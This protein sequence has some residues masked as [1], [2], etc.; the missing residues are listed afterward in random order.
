MSAL[1]SMWIWFVSVELILA[2]LPLLTLVRLFDRDPVRYRTGRWF[3]RL[4]IAMTKMNPSWRLHISG[5][6]I[7]DPR[8]PY[9][10]VSNHQSH[11]DI[12][13]I[14]HLP[15]EMKW[16]AKVE[17]FRLPVVGWMLRLA[18]DIP[19]DRQDRRQGV[20]VLARAAHYL[21]HRCSVMF[22]PEGTRSP[23]GR[24]HRFNEGAFRLAIKCG[25]PI[26]PLAV[27][28]SRD[29]LPKHSWKF[30]RPTDIFL[31]V[32]PPVETT[33][34]DVADTARLCE[35]VRQMIIRQLAAWRNVPPPIVDAPA[36]HH[37]GA[38]G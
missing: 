20:A 13:L 18:G 19:I 34:W 2:W 29:C 3:R 32:L 8:R 23:D 1:R 10:V 9:V 28:G 22:F 6:T 7:H 33:G 4:G 25:V 37:I 35:E 31:E 12:P 16:L 26:L 36:S 17:L 5:V 38:T 30:G 14:S 11:A 27:D 24:V 15:W 21:R